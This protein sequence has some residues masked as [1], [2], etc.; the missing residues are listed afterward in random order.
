MTTTTTT[1]ITPPR[2]PAR[3]FFVD[4]ISGPIERLFESHKE[5]LEEDMRRLIRKE[6]E[7]FRSQILLD[8][9]NIIVNSKDGTNDRFVGT[10]MQIC[11]PR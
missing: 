8:I 1:T 5:G 4:T 2:S 3:G 7:T 10:E 11:D 6:L 9:Q